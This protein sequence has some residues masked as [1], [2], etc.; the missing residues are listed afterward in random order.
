MVR[1]PLSPLLKLL[2]M[3]YLCHYELVQIER[4]VLK[5]ECCV[6]ASKE[7]FRALARQCAFDI[8]AARLGY[9]QACLAFGWEQSQDAPQADRQASEREE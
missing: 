9:D 7:H 3:A 5:Q 8:V 1:M 2:D 4:Y 6:L